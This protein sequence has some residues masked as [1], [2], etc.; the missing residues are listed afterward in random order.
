[1]APRARVVLGRDGGF[2]WAWIAACCVHLPRVLMAV[3][4][5]DGRGGKL[6]LWAASTVRTTAHARQL[7]EGGRTEI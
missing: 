5:N 3:R 2:Y 1:M 7:V 4:P 6:K